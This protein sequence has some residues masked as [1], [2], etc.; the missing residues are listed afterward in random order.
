MAWPSCEYN[1]Q[2]RLSVT[3][4]CEPTRPLASF[5][6]SHKACSHYPAEKNQRKIRLVTMPTILGTSILLRNL[7]RVLVGVI[8]VT[9]K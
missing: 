1:H 7:I 9:R 6:K 4:L 5:C 8:E 3:F 2:A